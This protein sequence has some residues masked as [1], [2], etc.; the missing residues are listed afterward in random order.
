MGK[1]ARGILKI[2]LAAGF[3][4]SM[5][6]VLSVMYRYWKEDCIYDK[7][8]ETFLHQVEGIS[9]SGCGE[10]GGFEQSDEETRVQAPITVDFPALQEKCED[11]VGWIYCEGT[12]IN[13]PVVQGEEN[14]Y[15]LSHNYEGNSNASGS[16]FVDAKNRRGFVDSNTILYGHNMKDGS[17]FAC[18]DNWADQAYYE[19]HPEMWLLT[20]EN[21]YRIVL[22]SGYTTEA[23]SD[24]YE[25][26]TNPC[27]KLEEYLQ[28][29]A[30]Q[31]DFRTDITL[32]RN[33]R[34]VVLS[35]CVYVFDDARYVLQGMLVPADGAEDIALR[36]FVRERKTANGGQR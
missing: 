25:I 24:T 21:D 28:H 20:P 31:S 2:I 5:G 27:E 35:T 34:Y 30:A 18:L 4:G 8:A 33:G 3:L 1:R 9:D 22:F 12:P 29:C 19:E 14:D 13:Y 32:D 36:K 7:A 17:M 26:F 10:S 11:V 15:Y 16:I 23:D 6:V